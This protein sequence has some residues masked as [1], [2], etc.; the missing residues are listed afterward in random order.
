MK[1]LQAI[2]IL[3]TIVATSAYSAD[4]HDHKVIPGPK[5]GKVLET[6]PLHA[7]FFVQP[8]RKVS[9]TFYDQ[10][11]KPVAPGEQVVKVIAEAPSGK[12]TLDFEKSGD[13][14]VSKTALPEGDDYRVVLQ[15]R[16]TA[17]GKPQNFRIDYSTET[18]SD[19]KRPEYACVCSDHAGHGH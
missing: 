12:T 10:A 7:E 5:G 6:D 2:L 18:C 9:V 4:E 8:D 16:Q 13:A 3:L 14:L 17:D 1:T 11:M 15:I 19:C